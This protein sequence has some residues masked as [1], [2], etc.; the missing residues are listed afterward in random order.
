MVSFLLSAILDIGK[1]LMQIN[2]NAIAALSAVVACSISMYQISEER[3]L[4][5]K[6]ILFNKRIDISVLLFK[7]LNCQNNAKSFFTK[8]DNNFNSIIV[9]NRVADCLTGIDELHEIYDAYLNPNDNNSRRKLL[10]KIQKLEEIAYKSKLLFPLPIGP[11][12]D[13]FYTTYSKLLMALYQYR[14]ASEELHETN[15]KWPPLQYPDSSKDMQDIVKHEY[16]K[17]YLEWN[18]LQKI[19]QSIKI[20]DVNSY[21]KLI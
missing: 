2:W 17:F 12:L 11:Q 18:K 10:I 5:N 4:T 7:L 14:I 1:D 16:D 8:K 20:E 19:A 6:Q 15:K 3:K 21:I 13:D 9:W